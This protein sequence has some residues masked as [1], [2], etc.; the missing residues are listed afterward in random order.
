MIDFNLLISC[1][2]R[3]ENEACSEVW[4]L[5]S[6]V[7]DENPAVEKTDVSGLI[8]AKTSMDPFQAVQKLRDLL[9]RS[10][11]EFRYTLKIVPIELTVPTRIERIEEAV[12]MLSE[13]IDINETFRV[14]VEKR[15]SQISTKE[16]IDVAAKHVSRK[17]NLEKPDKIVLI[18]VVGGVTGIS[19]IKP[20]DILS[21][22]KEKAKLG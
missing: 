22:V 1:A 2:R 8:T 7:G 19:V 16:I 3:M 12:R 11:E 18:E 5:L 4:F 17:V 14:T 20:D 10:P 13:K 6:E 9:M 15:H 21:V